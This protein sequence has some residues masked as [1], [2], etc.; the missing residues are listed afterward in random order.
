VKKEN[1][2]KVS[3]LNENENVEIPKTA[4]NDDENDTKPRRYNTR[5]K[6]RVDYKKLHD[7]NITGLT[8]TCDQKPDKLVY[9]WD[10]LASS[11]DED[12]MWIYRD[13]SVRSG[14]SRL[15]LHSPLVGVQERD[16]RVHS[17]KRAL[18]CVVTI[19][20]HH[21]PLQVEEQE[22][23][24]ATPKQADQAVRIIGHC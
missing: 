1:D 15:L 23:G 17:F 21:T 24:H 18:G 3:K 19:L 10:T 5:N 13:M 7:G 2:D 8:Q 14:V 16:V 9:A 11:D 12:D 20:L 4:R 22:R 6:T